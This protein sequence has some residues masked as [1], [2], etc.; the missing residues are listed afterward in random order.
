[1]TLE[2][3]EYF[4]IKYGQKKY[5]AHQIMRW[6]YSEAVYDF[7]KMTNIPKALREILNK[8]FNASLP[9]IINSSLEYDENRRS[10]KY[11]I[12]LRD[13]QTIESVFI[14]YGKRKTICVSSQI[15]CKMN[16]TFCTT[17]GFGFKRNLTSGEIITQLLAI[18]NATKNKI[19]NVVFMGMGEPLD[20]FEEVKK[21]VKI[22]M[23]S[24]FISIAPR[25]ITISTC[26]ILD[27]L[28]EIRNLKCKIAI[29]LNA[30]NNLIRD[31]LMPINKK[32]NVE[33]IAKVV[34]NTKPSLHNK[35]TIEYVL[36]K[37]INDK[38][39][40]AKQLI[41]LFSPKVTKFN[42]IPYNSQENLLSLKKY[43]RSDEK[44]CGDFKNKLLKAGFTVTTR[45][46]KAQGINGGCGQL[47][48][49]HSVNC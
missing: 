29:S 45:H 21:S 49:N 31:D 32:F 2:E 37:D 1:M 38:I 43:E 42:I 15:G 36:I 25:K 27:K 34:N 47:K 20:N 9:E 28:S 16:C 10:M 30:S 18:E 19:T 5:N 4:I 33:N 44:T 3:L 46:S 12:K 8:S 13:G 40:D 41:K 11:L 7:N 14:D 48:H 39:E 22:I 17:G 26:G 24:N 35:I 23:D 6:L